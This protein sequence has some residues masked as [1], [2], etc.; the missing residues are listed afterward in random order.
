MATQGRNKPKS[1]LPWRDPEGRCP[2]DVVAGDSPVM[3]R[4]SPPEGGFLQPRVLFSLAAGGYEGACS[5]RL[6]PG[7]FFGDRHL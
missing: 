1:P 3:S 5:G 7:C 6:I 4:T 2:Q